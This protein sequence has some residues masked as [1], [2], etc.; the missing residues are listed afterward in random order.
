MYLAEFCATTRGGIASSMEETRCGYGC[1]NSEYHFDLLVK[2]RVSR[3]VVFRTGA[4]RELRQ[5][6]RRAIV[7]L[8]PVQFAGVDPVLERR[9]IEVGDDLKVFERDHFGFAVAERAVGASGV[10]DREA[11]AGSRFRW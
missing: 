10:A 3:V 2:C 6:E 8:E 7:T 5:I 4:S 11:A 1:E 9:A